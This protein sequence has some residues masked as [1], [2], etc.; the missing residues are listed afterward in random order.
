MI[1]QTVADTV[2]RYYF[3]KHLD[4][5]TG[6][7]YPAK[8]RVVP[9]AIAELAK[10]FPGGYFEPTTEWGID[11]YLETVDELSV[12]AADDPLR[13]WREKMDKKLGKT[14]VAK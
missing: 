11:K 5:I 4:P 2:V 8:T 1:D 9:E 3:R 13:G 14:A 6:I 10:R 7:A 12:M